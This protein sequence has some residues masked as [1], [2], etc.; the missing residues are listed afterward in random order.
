MNNQQLT[1][2]AATASLCNWCVTI[3]VSRTKPERHFEFTV[4]AGSV[5]LELRES[6][7]ITEKPNLMPP[8]LAYKLLNNKTNGYSSHG[9][10]TRKTTRAKLKAQTNKDNHE[11]NS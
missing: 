7:L 9:N 6:R 1:T 10:E 8:K 3:S 5:I 2:L 11:T 4:T